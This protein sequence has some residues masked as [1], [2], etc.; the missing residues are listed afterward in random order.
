VNLEMEELARHPSSYRAR[1]AMKRQSG[2][3]VSVNIRLRRFE[4]PIELIAHEIEHVIEQLEGIDLGA[5]A[6]TGNVWKRDDGAFETRRAIEVGWRV[7]REVNAADDPTAS[8]GQ[9]DS[10][11]LRLHAIALHDR[12]PLLTGPPSGRVSP[13]GRQ[14]VVTSY[15]S[16]AA[17]DGNTTRDIYV[18]DVSTRRLTLET[19]GAGGH[20]A[21]G[22]SVNPDISQDGRFVV[23][24]STA[25]NLAT[26]EI[27][28]GIPRV[29]LRD[30]QTDIIR[31]L[32]TNA[33]DEPANGPSMNPAISADGE[34][35]VFV[36][37][38][39]DILEGTVAS[40]GVYL[41]RLASNTRT[42]VDVT[43]Q[44]QARSGQSASPVIS[45]DGR[46]VAFMSRADLTPRDG[47]SSADDA[48]DGNGTGDIYV[49]DTVMQ[50]TRRV[51]QGRGGRDTDGPS[52]H[53]AIS[54]DG[55]FVAF[56]SEA[57]NL[58]HDGSKR[59]AQIYLRD[60]DTGE[61]EL[62]SRGSAGRPGDAASARPVVSGDGSVIAYQS[63]AS[64]LLCDDTCGPS[65]RDINLL[66]DVYVYDRPVRRTIRAS[67]GRR[68]EWM[69]SSRGPS[70]DDTGRLLAFMSTHPSSP[71]DEGHGEDLFVLGLES[72]MSGKLPTGNSRSAS[73]RRWSCCAGPGPSFRQATRP[74]GLARRAP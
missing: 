54:G 36:S 38:A 46:Y 13:S 49:R 18:M 63:L 31:L 73:D 12:F 40:T 17:G 15:A 66:W 20:S 23:F 61:M 22:E 32:S 25:G 39:T 11:S 19:P 68:E 48:P 3:L 74:G 70:L 24:E 1:A 29:F 56:V 16:L 59:V 62:I 5:R 64:N 4:D 9:E 34:S 52:Y 57:S 50:R 60:M 30:R 37:S 33:R 55:R 65:E 53:P 42:R 71:G 2:A 7:A 43:N 35:V 27:A 69:E 58:T 67:T 21:N 10:V 41:I 72:R 8:D 47:S 51:S 28:R 6:G 44:G 26:G 45:A 14:V